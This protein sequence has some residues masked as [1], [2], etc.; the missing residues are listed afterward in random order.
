MT[1]YFRSFAAAA[2]LIYFDHLAVYFDHFG[3]KI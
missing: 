2:S 1:L 3:E